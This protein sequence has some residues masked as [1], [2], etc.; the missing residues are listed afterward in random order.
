MFFEC[1]L[2]THGGWLHFSDMLHG[3]IGALITLNFPQLIRC[4]YS[5]K[6]SNNSF[7]VLQYNINIAGKYFAPNKQGTVKEIATNLVMLL[8]FF[9]LFW[10]QSKGE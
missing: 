9:C 2:C 6:Y 5:C 7:C 3:Y 1:S 8:S 10:L 4:K